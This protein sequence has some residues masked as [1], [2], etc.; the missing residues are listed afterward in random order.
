PR[1]LVEPA[2][3]SG[4]PFLPNGCPGAD[5]RPGC[6]R[7]YGSYRP[8]EPFRDYPFVPT[9]EDLQVIR[10]QLALD[11]ILPSPATTPAGGPVP[12]RPPELG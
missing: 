8:S 5:G 2:V 6:T 3:S 10:A 9:G 7:P 4:L 1:A 12:S 11:E